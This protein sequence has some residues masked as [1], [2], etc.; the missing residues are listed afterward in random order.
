MS[1]TSSTDPL[2]RSHELTTDFS[3][4]LKS[5]E[6]ILLE[7]ICRTRRFSNKDNT[8]ACKVQTCQ[9]LIKENLKTHDWR[10]ERDRGE[11]VKTRSPRHWPPRSTIW[12]PVTGYFTC[13]PWGNKMPLSSLR[14]HHLNRRTN[15]IARD[16]FLPINQLIT[17][18]MLDKVPTRFKKALT[19]PI[20]FP[21]HST[22]PHFI[23]E[24]FFPK[25][26]TLGVLPREKR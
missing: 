6:N 18:K 5:Q 17:A 8:V 13:G 25:T 4:F 22:R 2:S 23:S 14:G 24:W 19:F 21:F 9:P 3:R 16:R 1:L 7:L 26:V 10:G 11:R 20:E 12:T 15:F